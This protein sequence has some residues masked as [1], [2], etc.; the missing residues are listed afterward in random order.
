MGIPGP[1]DADARE[2]LADKQQQQLKRLKDNPAQAQNRMKKYADLKRSK[3]TFQEGDMVYL[4]MQ[5]YR[6]A[7]FGARTCI[8]LTTKFYG[9]FRILQKVGTL[10]YKL[11]LPDGVKIHPVFHVS[12][13]KKH[14]GQRAVPEQGLPLISDD[15]KF[16]LNPRRS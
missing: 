8:K 5:P 14:L 3:R 12:Q 7:A 2:F 16:V 13:L 9:L 1:E 6:L 11:L 4:R 15:A 10:A